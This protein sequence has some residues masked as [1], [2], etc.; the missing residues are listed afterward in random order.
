MGNACSTDGA[1]DGPGYVSDGAAAC[2]VLARD[3]EEEEDP[4]VSQLRSE[5]ES[6]KLRDLRK[7]ALGA[8]VKAEALEEAEEDSDEPKAALVDLLLQRRR[9]TGAAADVLP[10]LVAG[11]EAAAGVLGLCLDHAVEVL[12]SLSTSLQRR[13]R[14]AALD[15]LE[16]VEAAAAEA[17]EADWCGGLAVSAQQLSFSA[18]Y[19]STVLV[20]LF[21]LPFL[22]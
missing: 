5:L 12:D 18:F 10:A 20:A 2:M 16:R 13:E 7:R 15:L 21:S 1:A 14:K 4:T 9:D 17:V 19:V 3:V 6:L 22:R 8:G 11:G